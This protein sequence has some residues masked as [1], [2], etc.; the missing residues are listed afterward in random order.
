MQRHQLIYLKKEAQFEVLTEHHVSQELHDYTVIVQSIFDWINKELPCVY[1]RQPMNANNT[2]IYLGLCI[3][4]NDKKHRVALRTKKNSIER[5][6]PL[7]TLQ[8][9]V[10]L[11]DNNGMDF[12]FIHV[13]GS[14]LFQYLSHQSFVKKNSDV[15][16]LVKYSETLSLQSLAEIIKKLGDQFNRGIDGEIRFNTH[17]TMDIAFKELLSNAETLLVKTSTDVYLLS[18][19]ELYDTYPTLYR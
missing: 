16:L 19:K 9:I 18:R 11:I 3:L 17:T 7:P 15:D 13:Y 5:E 2:D 4:L 12:S 1:V 14:F 10:P 8:Q 6:T